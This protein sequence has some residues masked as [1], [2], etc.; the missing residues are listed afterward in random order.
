MGLTYVATIPANH[1]PRVV[2]F[3][4]RIRGHTGCNTVAGPMA[5]DGS[6]IRLRRLAV[7]QVGC[8]SAESQVV[9][10]ALLDALRSARIAGM[11]GRQL[12]LVGEG[13]AELARF[14]AS[15]R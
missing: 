13:R 8:P 5:V 2:F 11:H 14:E 7:S 1:T 4:D 3:P 10:Q 9:E 6:S 12:V 15:S